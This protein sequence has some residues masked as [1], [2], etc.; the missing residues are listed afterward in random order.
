MAL[1]KEQIEGLYGPVASSASTRQRPGNRSPVRTPDATL[2]CRRCACV[3]ERVGTNQ[4][5][6]QRPCKPS[7]RQLFADAAEPE[8]PEQ[9]RT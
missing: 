7:H 4:Y 5:E 9:E 6:L 3:F 8:T 1:T 2:T